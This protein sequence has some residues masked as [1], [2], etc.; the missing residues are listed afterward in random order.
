[1]Y[2]KR[3]DNT[4]VKLFMPYLP[5]RPRMPGSF[6]YTLNPRVLNTR[7]AIQQGVF[8]AVGDV[9]KSLEDNLKHYENIKNNIVKIVIPDEVRREMLPKLH[10]M[11]I[12]RASL[13]PGLDGFAS[14]LKTKM[15]ALKPGN[16]KS[17]PVE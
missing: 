13:Y 1:M 14:S 8:T 12:S 5:P 10:R 2:E 7:L 17:L 15:Y 16:I 6:M 4:F 11:G 3:D 9:T